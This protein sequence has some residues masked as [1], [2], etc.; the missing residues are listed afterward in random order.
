M[1][2]IAYLGV[3]KIKS[4]TLILYRQERQKS[5]E[6]CQGNTTTVI[7]SYDDLL[8]VLYNI[9]TE[10]ELVY[11]NTIDELCKGLVGWPGFENV[12]TVSALY[13]DGVEDINQYLMERA[14]PSYGCWEYN[15]NL[16][17][18]KVIYLRC[19]FRTNTPFTPKL[20]LKM[21]LIFDTLL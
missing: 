7:E 18:T 2:N 19:L 5:E 10:T 20:N 3:Y 6:N 12:F 21:M 8:E 11:N 17:T 14:Y 13:G 4:I 1:N 16:V 9:R 15:E